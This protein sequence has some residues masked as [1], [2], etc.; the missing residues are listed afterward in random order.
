MESISQI[1][2]FNN[3]EFGNIRTMEK[4]GE[5]WFCIVDICKAL[6]ISNSRD[7]KKRLTDDGVASTDIVDSRGRKNKANFINESNLY[8][9]I[10]QSRKPSAEKFTEWI[11]SEVIPS[12]RKHGAYMTPE[13]IEKTLENPDFIIGLATKLKEEQEKTKAL[14]EDNARMKPKEIFADA[15]SGSKNSILIGDLAKLIAQNGFE[16][17]QKRLFQWLRDKKYIYKDGK[18]NV[19]YQRYV[20]QGLFERKETVTQIADAGQFIHITTK[21]TGKGQVYFLNKFVGAQA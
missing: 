14:S 15:V 5:P 3:S 8:K 16:I 1:E 9:L 18:N 13:T 2:V 11:S 6:D 17:G 19:P 21:V 4:D 10:F 7:A 12:I 20:E